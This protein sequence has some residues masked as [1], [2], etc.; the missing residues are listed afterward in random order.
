MDKI[1]TVIISEDFSTKEVLILFVSEFDNLETI[2]DFN[3]YSDIFNI[4][5]SSKGKYLLIVDLS[6]NKIKNLDFIL[7]VTKECKNC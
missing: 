4:L 7:Q 5:A 6:T 1:S 3:N 2:D